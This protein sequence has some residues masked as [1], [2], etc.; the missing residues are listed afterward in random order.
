[1][2]TLSERLTHA[3][4]ASGITS[5]SELSKLSRV[6]QSIISKILRGKN[7]TSKYA[8]KLAA[9]LGVSA[10]WLIN[11]AGNMTG[12][13]ETILEKIDASR[14]VNVWDEHGPTNDVISWTETIPSHF[15]AYIMS[16]NTGIIQ[17]P[18]GAV[19]LVDPNA[20]PGNSEL[21]VTNIRNEISVYRFLEGGSELGHLSVDDGRIPVLEVKDP[22]WI[23]GVA[24]QILV[25][26]L[27]K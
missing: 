18:A 4:S 12:G 8:G 10:D 9:A 5:Q 1:M 13:K 15:R 2:K 21:V 3:M 7:E 14:L 23:L 22:S 6:N 25:R 20:K 27:R 26:R 11:G 19:V 17:A 16:K 24:E